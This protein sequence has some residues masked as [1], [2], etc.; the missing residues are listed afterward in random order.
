M[1]G[2]FGPQNDGVIAAGPSDGWGTQFEL[3]V[4][5]HVTIRRLLREA[6]H[7]HCGNAAQSSSPRGPLLAE[8]HFRGFKIENEYGPVSRASGP[9]GRSY[10]TWAAEMAVGLETGVPWVMCKEDDAPDPVINTC[11]GFYCDTFTP[12]TPYKPMMWTEAW[13]GCSQTGG[14]AAFL[15]NYNPDSFARVMFN[16]AYFDAPDGNDPL[17]LDMGSMGKGQ[18]NFDSLFHLDR[19]ALDKRDVWLPSPP[20]TSAGTHA[21]MS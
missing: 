4:A 18:G 6:R 2:L 19:T 3:Y 20:P 8:C 10:L 9:A 14:C 11:N 17:A 12:N 16:N 7:A 15:A 13:S 1:Q 5:W 21:Q